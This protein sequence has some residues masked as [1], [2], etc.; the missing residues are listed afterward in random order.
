MKLS[1]WMWRYWHQI[2]VHFKNVCLFFGM[3]KSLFYTRIEFLSS[4]LF[5]QF[6]VI[7]TEKYFIHSRNEICKQWAIKVAKDFRLR[8]IWCLARVC[9]LICRWPSSYILTVESRD[10]EAS[11]L[12]SLL[13]SSSSHIF[14]SNGTN[15]IH[16]GPIT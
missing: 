12:I 16:E 3:V 4:S 13:I 8:S 10:R 14:S 11:S 1:L 2:N 7:T 15:P 9:F 6:M 5:V